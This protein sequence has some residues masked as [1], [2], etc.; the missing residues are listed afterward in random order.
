[1][2]VLWDVLV[3]T[4]AP[5][6]AG[7]MALGRPLE[8]A[9][10]TGPWTPVAVVTAVV[11]LRGVRLYRRLWSQATVLDLERLLLGSLVALTLVVMAAGSAPALG[12]RAGLATLLGLL[13]GAP[14]LAAPRVMRALMARH[15]TRSS[16][17]DQTES[18]APRA[19]TLIL[20]AGADARQLADALRDQPTKASARPVGFVCDEEALDG[21][22][23]GGLPVAAP[24][25]RL[26]AVAQA[27]GAQQLLLAVPDAPG[28]DVRR[29]V[30][31]AR[32]AG[33]AVRTVPSLA[34][35]SGTHRADGTTR[36]RDVRIEDLLRRAPRD[37]DPQVVRSLVADRTVCVTGAGGS[38]GS[39]LC[40]QLAEAG[41]RR[42]ILVGRGENSVFEIDRELARRWPSVDRLPVILDVRDRHALRRLLD[43]TAPDVVFH[44]AAH[45][46]V[47]YMEHE[48][49]EALSVN[50]V[51]TWRLAEQCAEAGVQRFVLVSTDKAVSPVNAMGASKRAAE[52]VVRAMAERVGQPW[53]V[54]RFGNVLG[55]R[56][57]VVPTFLR[58]INDGGPVT[59]TDRRMTRY[60]MTIPEAASL[61]IEAGARADVAG[62]LYMLDMGAPVAIADLASDLIRLTGHQPDRD[63]AIVETG[64]R[65]GELLHESLTRDDERL[66]CTSA[67]GIYSVE[68]C[69]AADA[70]R[71]LHAVPAIA[72]ALHHGVS[73][74]DARTLLGLLVPEYAARATH[75]A[76]PAADD[77]P[78]E[79]IDVFPTARAGRAG[80]GPRTPSA[81]TPPSRSHTPESPIHASRTA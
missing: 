69:D 11:V 46:H 25:S 3:L 66:V 24:V 12:A 1:V 5:W 49:S 71:V 14:L 74:D 45:K 73:D 18:G 47:P 6:L 30:A 26:A 80:A 9:E 28:A 41:A 60:F 70:R 34:E 52:L 56:G 37:G 19:R 64:L 33:L 48:P 4:I 39:E 59:L 21:T 20:G 62:A 10:A 76:T 55:S 13:L 50:V 57:S 75:G 35:S 38:I 51:G 63:I 22:L 79:A 17:R 29:W 65:P 23:L 27:L 43:R 77:A 2:L 16:T 7:S 15:R 54:V 72:N 53:A 32:D 81:L 36:L 61:V 58:Q 31:L 44:A 8:W 78:V 68:T 67:A 40:R 42:L